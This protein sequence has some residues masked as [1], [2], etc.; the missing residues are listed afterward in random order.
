MTAF[1]QVAAGLGI[2]FFAW[3]GLSWVI[4]Q[5]LLRM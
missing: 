4:W 2:V 5:I 3:V 1:I